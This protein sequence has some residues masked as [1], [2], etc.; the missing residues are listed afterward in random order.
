[1]AATWSTF[2]ALCAVS[3]RHRPNATLSEVEKLHVKSEST[4]RLLDDY[5]G[6]VGASSFRFIFGEMTDA[7]LPIG[8]S[9][10]YIGGD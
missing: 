10:A 3:L 5:E 6:T 2:R 9:L 4:I 7:S 1:M 8:L